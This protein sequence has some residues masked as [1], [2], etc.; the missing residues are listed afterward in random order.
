MNRYRFYF[1]LFCLISSLSCNENEK[2]RLVKEWS[3]K[4]IH[5]PENIRFTRYGKDLVDFT[6][7]VNQYKILVYIDSRG[8]TSCKLQLTR[9]KSWIS[10][11]D[12]ITQKKMSVVFFFGSKNSREIYY[13][14]KRDD[15]DTPI[16]IDNEDRLNKINKFPSIPFFQTFLLDKENKV[17]LIGNP[18][19]SPAMK[20][21]YTKQIN[22]EYMAR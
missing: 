20:K 6:L 17:L 18:I 4:K 1:I 8:C 3:G 5:F 9:W 13:L 10:E 12:S 11:L 15:F 19:L 14:L 21:L 7:P 2:I 16:C 22:S